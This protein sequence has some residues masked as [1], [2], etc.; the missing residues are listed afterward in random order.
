M[1]EGRERERE[2]DYLGD[3]APLSSEYQA[4]PAAAKHSSANKPAGRTGDVE[5][6]KPSEGIFVR[7][8]FGTLPSDPT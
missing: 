8:R 2:V 6:S 1:R 3:P 4:C 5:N 7:F